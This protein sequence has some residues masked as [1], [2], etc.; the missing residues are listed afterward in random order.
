VFSRFL[1]L[2]VLDFDGLGHCPELVL[3]SLANHRSLL[4]LLLGSCFGGGGV[5]LAVVLVGVVFLGVGGWLFR[6]ALHE[7][8]G[9]PAA[10]ATAPAPPPAHW[11]LL[12]RFAFA[13]LLLLRVVLDFDWRLV[14]F[15]LG[16]LHWLLGLAGD[17]LDGGL[18]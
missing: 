1:P 7:F 10:S 15:L 3:P 11:G 17:F 5:R 4:V 14:A 16:L 13:Q 18:G 2:V 6:V 8:A 12:D 9:C